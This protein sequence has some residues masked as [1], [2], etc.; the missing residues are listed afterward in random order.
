LA[1]PTHALL[2]LGAAVEAAAAVALV[3]LQVHAPALAAGLGRTA[4]V[5]AATTVALVCLQIYAAVSTAG[6]PFGA[7]GPGH[8]RNE[9]KH[10]AH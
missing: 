5:G 7:C 9:A 10:A 3:P 2:A 4:T 8:P 6:L 1:H